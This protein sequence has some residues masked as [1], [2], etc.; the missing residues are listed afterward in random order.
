MK[1]VYGVNTITRRQGQNGWGA[2]SCPLSKDS[3]PI[4]CWYNPTGPRYKL[5]STPLETVNISLVS[6]KSM[7][8]CNHAHK[9]KHQITP[10]VFTR[11]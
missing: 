10:E 4:G 1:V 9:I 3:E 6:K 2:M 5:H 11:Q 7:V 8:L